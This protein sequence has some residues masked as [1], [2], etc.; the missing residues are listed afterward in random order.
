MLNV[1]WFAYCYTVLVIEMINLALYVEWVLLFLFFGFY[2]M[3]LHD[4]L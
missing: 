4:S 1:I 2:C 3:Q